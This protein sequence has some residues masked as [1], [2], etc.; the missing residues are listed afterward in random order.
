MFKV[1]AL[2]KPLEVGGT[3]MEIGELVIASELTGSKWGDDCLFFRHQLW[4][5]DLKLHPEWEH[6]RTKPGYG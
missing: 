6:Y 4:D 2:D 5:D 3:Y 1:N